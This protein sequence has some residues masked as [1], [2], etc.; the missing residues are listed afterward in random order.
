MREML[1]RNI[2]D[3]ALWVAAFRGLESNRPDALFQDPYADRLAGDR[4][5]SLAGRFCFRETARVVAL[6]TILID[7]IIQASIRDGVDAV[8]SLAAGLDSRPYRMALPP[9]FKWYEVDLPD[10]IAYKELL[11]ADKVPACQLRRIPLDLSRRS[12]RSA[13]FSQVNQESRRVLIL[14]EG[15]LVYLNPLQVRELG[16][17]L[18]SYSH[19][20][21]WVFDLMNFPLSWMK[22]LWQKELNAARIQFKFAPPEGTAFFRPMGWGESEYH[23]LFIAGDRFNRDFPGGKLMRLALGKCSPNTLEK[24][25]QFYGIAALDRLETP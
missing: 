21:R 18:Y 25:N 16:E 20:Q 4:I 5:T 8:L 19:Y 12:P 22:R 24:I 6:R 3:T 2:S 7:R 1:I 17:D 14:T 15:L 9:D 10:L 13:L 23:S 11:L